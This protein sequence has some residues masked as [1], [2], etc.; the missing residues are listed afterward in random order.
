MATISNL[1]ADQGSDFSI[2]ITVDDAGGGSLDLT[3]Y[4]ARAQIRKTY[5]S[6][7]AIDFVVIIDAPESGEIQLALSAATTN[8]MK[9]GRYVYDLEIEDNESGIVTRVVEGQ[10]TITPSVTRES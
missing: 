10:I 1:A 9:P 2:V 3:N 4:S 8:G 5:A 6:L 7:T